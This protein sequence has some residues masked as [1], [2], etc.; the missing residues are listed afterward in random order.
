MAKILS[1]VL[2]IAVVLSVCGILGVFNATATGEKITDYYVGYSESGSGTGLAADSPVASIAEAVEIMNAN[3]NLTA[4]DTA[5]IW[6]VQNAEKPALTET[7]T[8][9]TAKHNL[10][11]VVKVGKAQIP[12]HAATISIKPYANNTVTT[13]YLASSDQI[14]NN[15]KPYLGGPTIIDDL[16]LLYCSDA[17]NAENNNRIAIWQMNGHNFEIGAGVSYGVTGTNSNKG[18]SWNGT[19][20]SAKDTGVEITSSTAGEFTFE[21][22]IKFV[23]KKGS[24]SNSNYRIDVPACQTTTNTFKSDVTIDFNGA[25]NATGIRIGGYASTVSAVFEKNLN[26]RLTKGSL[27]RF[28]EGA[29]S[30]K[31]NGGVQIIANTGFKHRIGND[32]ST[33]V[34][35]VVSWKNADGTKTADLWLL[36]VVEA[37]IDKIDYIQDV[38]GKFSVAK[39]YKATATNVATGATKASE[40]GV[41][42]LAGLPGE[43][44]VTF[45]EQAEKVYDYYVKAGGTGDGTDENNPAPDVVTAIT[46]MNNLGLTADETANIWIMQDIAKPALV[47]ANSI[48]SY[49]THNLTYWGGT[50]PE[51]AAKI[52]VKPYS[53]NHAN[54]PGVTTTYLATGRELGKSTTVTLGGPT[55]IDGLTMVLPYGSNIALQTMFE[56]NGK[57]FT[58]GSGFATGY[59]AHNSSNEENWNG[60]IKNPNALINSLGKPGVEYDKEIKVTYNNNVGAA[61][62]GRIDIPSYNKGTFKFMEDVTYEFGGISY[63]NSLRF[64][65]GADSTTTF[66]KNLNFK[67]DYQGN[68]NYIYRLYNGSSKVTIKGGVQIINGG[69]TFGGTGSKYDAFE[70]V[71]D[72]VDVNGDTAPMWHLHVN[73]ADVDK[74]NFISGVTGKFT[75]VKEGYTAIAYNEDKSIVETANENGV[76]NLE[77]KPGTYTVEFTEKIVHVENHDLDAYINYRGYNTAV[78]KNNGALANASKKLAT[79]KELNVVYFGGSVTAGSGSTN[80]GSW[81]GRISDWLTKSFPTVK[82]NNYNQAIGETGTYL[83]C[84]RVV[85]DIV[86]KAP[87]ILFIE[88]SINDFYDKA[89]DARTSMQFETIVRNVKEAYPDCDIV[90]VLVTDVNVADA[91]AD[92]Y[93]HAQAA[94]HEAISAK[95]NISTLH[96]GRY[97]ATTLKAEGCTFS[98]SADAVW[99]KYFDDA[100]GG[101]DIVHPNNKGYD[102][103]YQVVNAFMTNCLVFGDSS[104]YAV[105]NQVLPE[106]VNKYLFD[107]EVTYIDESDVTFTTEGGTTLSPDMQGI[108]YPDYQGLI[109]VPAGSQDVITVE[110]NGTE[111]IMLSKSGHSSKA[112]NNYSVRIDGGEWVEYAYQGKNPIVIASGLVGGDHVAEIKVSPATNV[113]GNETDYRISGFYSRNVEKATNRLSILDLVAID[114]TI[115]DTSLDYRDFN[116][117]HVISIND[118]ATLKMILLNNR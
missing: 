9:G 22:P 15:T 54:N 118:I 56:I 13:T 69:A 37:N 115:D 47:A 113:F 27:V 112:G 65:N 60:D 33:T 108:V 50:S 87:D 100:E 58:L 40:N 25:H 42:D 14:G 81:R 49:G 4:T 104:N 8:S 12:E 39:G 74:V 73:K 76:I 72:F 3:G 59:V 98:S 26:I 70:K 71:T 2:S 61:T 101:H 62:Q 80:N 64:G 93:L 95:Y 31:I 11:Y 28:F 106:M 75:A 109:R 48:G 29:G 116:N 45:E 84:Y 52:I 86:S 10:A 35:D 94:V 111:L 17:T 105:Q 78:T 77:D 107:G 66:E 92:G 46:K 103:Y 82:V 117:D 41:L 88:Y 21:K 110:F 99:A 34:K 7:K 43:Y 97:L 23:T 18:Y 44:T 79:E 1:I 53:G 83:G 67:F 51:H 19:P 38:T 89:S 32:S 6:I 57:N 68:D 36:N 55:E 63:L 114:E 20:V 102:L 16:Y 90:T 85:R 5:N 91:A 96:V 24:N 30:V